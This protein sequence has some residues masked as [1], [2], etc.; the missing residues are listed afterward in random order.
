MMH[1]PLR[2]RVR[3]ALGALG[4]WLAFHVIGGV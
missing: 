4:A 3:R 2:Y 1:I